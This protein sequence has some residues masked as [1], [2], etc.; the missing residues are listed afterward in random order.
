MA[1]Q[2]PTG[3]PPTGAAAEPGGD[4]AGSQDGFERLWTPHRL[5]YITGE[6]PSESAGEGCPFCAA[7]GRGDRDG[8]I[9]HRGETCFV[10]M[11]LFPYNPGHVLI[12]PYRH[13]SLYVDLTDE[14]TV[15]FT[16]LTK[17]AIAA[18]QTASNPHGYNIGMNQGAVAGAGVAAHLHQHIVPRW[19]G[20][21]NFL[22]IVGQTKALPALLEDV[23]TQIAEA[24]AR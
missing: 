19:A 16:A 2:D 21:A 10:V 18:L 20:D 24:W 17:A 5:A 15:E 6:R 4:F 23:R 1:S 22:P 11:N 9:V 12:C 7:P 8:L 3:L 14:E 13:V